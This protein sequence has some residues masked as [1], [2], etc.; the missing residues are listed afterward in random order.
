MIAPSGGFWP[1]GSSGGSGVS[2]F[3]FHRTRHAVV[4]LE[5]SI[6][7]GD[8]TL[9][10]WRSGVM[11]SRI[12]NP[13]PCVRDD[14]IVVLD[15]D[16]A[17]RRR[18]HV[19]PQRLPMSAVVERDIDGAFGAGEQQALPLRILADG[20]D[21]LAVGNAGDDL[22]P[23]LPAVVRAEDVRPQIVEAERVD[24]G[25]GRERIEVDRRR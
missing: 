20:I 23:G 10:I 17:H 13:R 25:V 7:S 14:E 19:Q 22:R 15:D 6:A 5:E 1:V 12:Q 3:V 2:V 16:V 11:S 18:R 9:S 21:R 4:R 24:R 8:A